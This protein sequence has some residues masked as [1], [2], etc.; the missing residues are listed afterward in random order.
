MTQPSNKRLPDNVIL[1]HAAQFADYARRIQE[2]RKQLINEQK[3]ATV[4]RHTSLQRQ[5]R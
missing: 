2:S 4:T 5:S 1:R 3:P